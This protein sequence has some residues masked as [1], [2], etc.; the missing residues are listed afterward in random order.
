MNVNKDYIQAAQLYLKLREGDRALI[1][2]K[3]CLCDAGELTE[4]SQFSRHFAVSHFALDTCLISQRTELD[5]EIEAEVEIELQNQQNCEISETEETHKETEVKKEYS[6]QSE[7]DEGLEGNKLNQPFYSL[8][9]THP[10]LIHYFIQLLRQ[11]EYLWRDEFKN[12][13]FRNE[14]TESAQQIGRSLARRFNVKLRPQTISLSARALLNW[15]RRQYA[16]HI[17]NRAFRT[18]H[19]DYYD[20][21][22]KFVPIS[23]IS[24]VNCDK[25]QRRFINED[26]LRRHKHRI[27]FGGDPYVCDVCQKGFV[28]ASKLRMHQNRF[29]KKYTRWS[30]QMCSYSAPSKWDLKSHVASHSGDRNFICELCG[31]STKS[32]SSLA[33]HRRTHSEPTIKCPYCPNKY[34]ETYLL[35]CHI[36]KS[37][38]IE[39]ET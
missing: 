23:D 14:R 3:C 36:A 15:F 9:N 37:H 25:C 18:R 12:M 21:L 33:V 39:E 6:Y 38:Y 17:S 19:Q 31:V 11:H 20:K 35:N 28:H 32:S 34:R 1:V 7:E 26:Q 22:L 13:D 30:C 16:L 8:Q 5:D 2:I 4:W 24:V 10:K 29:H 27:H